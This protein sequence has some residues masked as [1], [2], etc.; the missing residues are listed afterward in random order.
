MDCCNVNGLDRMFD[1]AEAKSHLK[2]YRKKGLDKRAQKIV[3]FL[4]GR[5]VSGTT[6]LE[7]GSG[8]GALHLE[9]L[10]E[11]A[12]GAVGVDVSSAQMEAAKSLAQSLG[13]QDV[14][15]YHLGDFVE[16][17]QNIAPVDIVLLDRVICCYPDML[18]LVTSSARHARRFYAITF[19]RGVR[20]L[21]VLL[22]LVVNAFLVLQRKGFRVFLHAPE[23]IKKTVDAQGLTQVFHDFSGPWEVVVFERRG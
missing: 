22:G 14:V 17:Q 18:G 19:P 3:D 8:I 4:K 11:G 21:H 20:W 7:V 1:Q 23:E 13:Y 15:E 5:G 2:A 6:L 10:K 9:L 12:G 16:L